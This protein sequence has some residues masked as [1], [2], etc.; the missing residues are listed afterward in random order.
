V[1]VLPAIRDRLV[2]RL[3]AGAGAAI[4]QLG[5]VG[6]PLVPPGGDLER[7]IQ[8]GIVIVT[9]AQ[10]SPYGETPAKRFEA[11]V[12]LAEADWRD[13][14]VAAGLEHTDWRRAAGRA[15]FGDGD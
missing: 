4:A 6:L 15:G 10:S 3:G 7:R 12:A 11:A 8:I 13:L 1:T 2:D 5:S 14:L 9:S